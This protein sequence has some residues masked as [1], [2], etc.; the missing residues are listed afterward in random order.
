MRNILL[1]FVLVS[2]VVSAQTPDALFADANELYRQ[3]KFEEALKIYRQIEASDKFS[4]EL[5]YNMANCYYKLNKVAPSIYNY[6]TA[7]VLDPLNE[8]AQNNLKI[9]HK[10]TLDRI[11]PLPKTLF[12]K[13]S[14]SVL[15]KFHYN[16]W[17]YLSVGLSIIASFLFIL[18][19]LSYDSGKK[20]SFF[21]LSILIF[22]FLLITLLSAYHQFSKS[23]LKKE[24]IIFATEVDIRNAPTLSSDAVFILH[25]GTKVSIMDSVDDWYKIKLID[26]KIGWIKA[27]DIKVIN[28]F[29]P[30]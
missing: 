14:S 29:L 15:G 26:G 7:L 23:Q 8:D 12:Q 19:Y 2:S 21:I 24:A 18:F 20:R 28:Q 5:Y 4:S 6:E 11:E 13:F 9:A 25:E 22:F 16:S 30:Q 27:D 1:F 17:A 3:D 10:L